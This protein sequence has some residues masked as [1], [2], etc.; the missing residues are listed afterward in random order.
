ME[1]SRPSYPSQLPPRAL[2][3]RV[4]GTLLGALGLLVLLSAIGLF[5]VHPLHFAARL[6][7][8]TLVRVLAGIYDPDTKAKSGS[9]ALHIAAREGNTEVARVLINAGAD[10]DAR[11]RGGQTALYWAARA[12][13]VDFARILVEAG[14]DVDAQTN[15]GSTALG[16]ARSRD[17]REVVELL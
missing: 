14:A 10:L 2:A 17:H 12:G 7:T 16:A 5:P 1:Q 13:H 4:A 6:E 11:G 15:F 8:P 3:R 9:T